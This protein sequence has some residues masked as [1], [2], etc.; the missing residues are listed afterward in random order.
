MLA[1]VTK[2]QRLKAQEILLHLTRVDGLKRSAIMKIIRVK[3]P[4]YLSF[5]LAMT[6]RIDNI[7][8][9]L[10]PAEVILAI[11]KWHESQSNGNKPQ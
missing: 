3:N 10:C 2:D 6:E 5:A 8:K 4:S 9:H 1:K 11:I 7:N